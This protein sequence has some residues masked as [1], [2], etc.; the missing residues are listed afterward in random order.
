MA[1]EAQDYILRV[2][3]YSDRFSARPGETIRFYV[4]S[5]FD[6]SYQ[7]DIVRLIHGDTNP[8]SPGFKEELIH[9]PVSDIYP[10]KHQ[11]I[12]AGSYVLVPHH[13]ELNLTSFTLCAYIYPTTPYVDVEGVQVGPQAILSKWDVRSKRRAMASLSTIKANFAV[14]IGHGKGKSRGVFDRQAPVPEEFGTR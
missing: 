8:E 4:H 13:E 14:R 9:T 7:A 1:T 12:H 2:T 3:G 11:A 6:E 5:E 10:G